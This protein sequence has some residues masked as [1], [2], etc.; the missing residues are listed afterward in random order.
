VKEGIMTEPK[1]RE[2]YDEKTKANTRIEG[3]YR[4]TTIHQPCFFCAEPDFMVYR[5]DEVNEATRRGGVCAHCKRGVRGEVDETG[6]SVS[7]RLMQTVGPDAPPWAW[8][9]RERNE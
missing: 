9:P 4:D 2:E 5:L 8:L 7:I 1:S 3:T 6:S